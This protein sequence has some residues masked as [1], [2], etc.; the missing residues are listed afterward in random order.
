MELSK[1]NKFL[2]AIDEYKKSLVTKAGAFDIHYKIAE[3]YD[4]LKNYDQVIF[5][6]NEI[7]RIDNYNL[8]V[9][10][11]A[12]LRMLAQAYYLINNVE[13][14]FQTYFEILKLNSD[15]AEA[16]YHISFIALGQGE[17]EIA[18][19]YFEKLVELQD[20]FESPPVSLPRSSPR[21]PGPRCGW[22]RP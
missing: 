6:L 20:D 12:V 14:A 7:L 22:T 5:H 16:H 10:K 18:Q 19:R 8:E 11:L 21:G 13:K 3:L 4:K 17:F 15:D 9:Q 1:Q 2:E